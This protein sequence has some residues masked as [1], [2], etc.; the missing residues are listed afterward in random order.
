[1]VLVQHLAA[2]VLCMLAAGGI[3]LGIVYAA[4]PAPEV[5]TVGA[6][7]VLSGAFA[8]VAGASI[9]VVSEV[10]LDRGETAMFSPEVAGPTVVIRTLWPPAV[11]M[12]GLLPVLLAQRAMRGG[13]P[14]VGPAITV[15]VFALALVG[16]VFLWVR[17]RAE[18]HEAV[19]LA[20]KG[21]ST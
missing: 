19:G 5:L 3:A 9:S 21:A 12:I 15:A 7:T 4:A 14:V 16:V 2:P 13:D 17:Y 18:M 10:V 11:A 8:A 1:V 6:I 20:Q